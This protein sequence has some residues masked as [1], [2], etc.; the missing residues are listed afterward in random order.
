M[1]WRFRGPRAARLTSGVLTQPG[2]LT[3]PLTTSLS[4]VDT[5]VCG[6]ARQGPR[7]RSHAQAVAELTVPPERSRCWRPALAGG[8]RAAPSA[9]PGSAALSR[10]AARAALP[11]GAPSRR[12]EG[13]RVLRAAAGHGPRDRQGRRGPPSRERPRAQPQEQ[14]GHTAPQTPAESGPRHRLSAA[15]AP[16]GERGAF[17]S[18]RRTPDPPPPRVC[19]ELGGGGAPDTRLASEWALHTAVQVRY[20]AHVVLRRQ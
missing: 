2:R 5:R 17:R 13:A 18:L 1:A 19:T 20:E 6:G 9:C 15:T 14:C 3:R 11:V 16:A 12:Q 4:T 7:E 10:P 8:H